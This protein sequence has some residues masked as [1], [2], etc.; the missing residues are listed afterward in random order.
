MRGALCAL[1]EINS[2]SFNAA[3][4][5][6]CGERLRALFAPLGAQAEFIDLPPYRDLDDAGRPRTRPLGRALR[7][8]QRPDAA[9]RVFL[10][11]HLDTVFGLEHPFQRV[12]ALDGDR[13]NGPGVADLKGGLLVMYLAL[14]ALERSATRERIGWEALFNPDEE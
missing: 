11:G 8:R 1:A 7:L 3:G 5:N 13:L 12:R 4:V 2:G 6:A 10:C 9:L 14:A